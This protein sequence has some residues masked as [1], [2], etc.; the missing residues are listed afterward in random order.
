MIHAFNFCGSRDR[1]LRDLMEMTLKRYA[2]KMLSSFQSFDMDAA[3]YGNGAGWEAA[4]MK[5]DTLREI[6]NKKKVQDQEWILSVDSDVV[7]CSDELFKYIRAISS[8]ELYR[9]AIVGIH[10]GGELAKCKMGELHNFSGCLILLRGNVA[11]YIA[12]LSVDELNQV[13]GEFKEYVITENEDVVISYL[14][15]MASPE[16]HCPLPEYI[17][18]SDHGFEWDLINGDRKPMY[19][20]NYDSSWFNGE[21]LGNPISGKWDI[22]KILRKEKIYL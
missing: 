18:H 5:I 12:A 7:F 6:V 17:Y 20:L 15:Q 2:G 13:R 10:Q 11:K 21:F 4:M 22:P 1:D 14:A 3:G 8:H 19:H 9:P 16:N